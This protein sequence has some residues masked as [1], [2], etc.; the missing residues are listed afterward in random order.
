MALA[1]G[2]VIIA[3][4]V[5]I[6]SGVSTGRTLQVVDDLVLTSVALAAAV[7]T[8]LAARAAHGRLRASW[9][10]LALGFVAFAAG[11][12]IWTGY[13]LTGHETPFP[14]PA[15]AVFLLF[16]VGACVGLLLYPAERNAGS[17]GRVLIDGFIVA[18]SL[19]LI[20]WVTIL[21][22]LYHEPETNRLHFAVSFSYPITDLL[23]LTVAAVVLVRAAVEQRLVLTLLTLG[24]ACIAL[25]D[26]G[27][28]YQLAKGEY[29]SGNV[30]DIAWVAGLLLVTVA[31]TA[32]RHA[33]T[34]E[35]GSPEP[36]G[37]APIL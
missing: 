37:W 19:F 15:D 20:S 11:E 10:A 34:A 26:S 3:F 5:W 12:M 24:L 29:A 21:E 23:I 4:A 31:A 2:A 16:P 33:A 7:S 8:A 18:G 1:A 30:V 17:R 9:T 22:R 36:L 32:G 13:E 14:S 6:L 35:E 28:A 25:A 27:Y